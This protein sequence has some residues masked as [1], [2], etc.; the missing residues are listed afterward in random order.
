MTDYPLNNEIT[1]IW[2]EWRKTNS[3]LNKTN[4]IEC[5]QRAPNYCLKPEPTRTGK[6]LFV[7]L[8]PSYQNNAHNDDFFNFDE[9]ISRAKINKIAQL[10]ECSKYVKDKDG[11]NN[12]NYYG[13][14]FNPLNDISKALNLEFY[15]HDMFLMRER[16]S[17]T[18]KSLI[19]DKHTDLND[20]GIA[21]FKILNAYIEDAQPRVIIIP[22]AMASR[23]FLKQNQSVITIDEENGI[24]YTKT[25]HGK[26]PTILCGSWQYGRLDEFTRAILLVH[27]KRAILNAFIVLEGQKSELNISS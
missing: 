27:L 10:N 11:N 1:K 22:N 23:Y 17:K 26:T 12:K 4:N 13:K 21:Q 8:N 6:I 5:M 15:H 14:Y 18:V 3:K 9:S 19:E 25:K 20:F 7:G 2:V 16:S 24:Y